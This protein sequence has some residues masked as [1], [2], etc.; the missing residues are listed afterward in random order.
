M[1]TPDQYR[2]KAVEY[3]ESLKTSTDPH[4]RRVYQELRR[5]FGELANKEQWL[6]DNHQRTLSIPV[7][8]RSDDLS[9]AEEEEHML[10]CLGAALIMQWDTLPTKLRRELFD[11]AGAMGELSDVAALRGQIARFLHRTTTGQKPRRLAEGYRAR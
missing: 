7:K 8:S 6:S 9:L 10:R 11:N 2:A 1:F 4:V 5:H 3:G